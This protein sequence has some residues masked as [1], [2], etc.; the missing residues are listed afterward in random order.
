[1]RACA[2]PIAQHDRFGRSADGADD[3]GHARRIAAIGHG[4]DRHAQVR[5]KLGRKLGGPVCRW[6]DRPHSTMRS[7]RRTRQSARIC[8]RACVPVPK[9]ARTFASLRA[10][11][12]VAAAVAQ[13]VRIVVTASASAMQVHGVGVRIEGHDHALVARTAGPD[14]IAGHVDQLRAELRRLPPDR[15]AS[16]RTARHRSAPRSAAGVA[17]CPLRTRCA[18]PA[19]SP[20]CSRDSPA[21]ARPPRHHGMPPHASTGLFASAHGTADPE[22]GASRQVHNEHAE[23]HGSIIFPLSQLMRLRRENL[24]EC[25]RCARIGA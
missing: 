14:R 9:M 25:S 1:M 15:R 19:A 20:R 11:A 10:S 2:H 8:A 21:T 24:C 16:R 17:P 12:S 22:A 13:A 5:R 23:F 6:A 3:I 18:S 7:N 4:L